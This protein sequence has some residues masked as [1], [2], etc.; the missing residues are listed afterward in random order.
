MLFF[1]YLTDHFSFLFVSIFLSL[2]CFSLI[3]NFLVFLKF[4]KHLLRNTL[5][6]LDRLCNRSVQFNYVWFLIFSSL[7]AYHSK[8]LKFQ[9]RKISNLIIFSFY[10]L[11]PI[12]FQ[13]LIDSGISESILHFLH[14]YF[15]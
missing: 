13:V 15:L 4:F 1:Q 9:L 7:E 11:F 12:F 14:D 8:D 10:S 6:I 3:K 2:V 5:Y